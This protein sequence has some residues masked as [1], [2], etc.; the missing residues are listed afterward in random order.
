MPMRGSGELIQKDFI[1]RL[2]HC[3]L[4]AFRALKSKGPDSHLYFGIN[5]IILE[6]QRRIHYN[7]GV[8]LKALRWQG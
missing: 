7:D 6:N 1:M 5:R 4:I 8:S 2:H 3:T